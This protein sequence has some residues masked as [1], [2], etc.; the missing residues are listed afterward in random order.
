MSNLA[1]RLAILEDSIGGV[2]ENRLGIPQRQ[3]P[4]LFRKE[5]VTKSG[6]TFTTTNSDFLVDYPNIQNVPNKFVN[7]TFSQQS[8]GLLVTKNDL[9]V[10]FGRT[11]G[12]STFLEGIYSRESNTSKAIKAYIN[13]IY[14]AET[15]VLSSFD[16]QANIL[17]IL[18][19]SDKDVTLWRLILRRE[20]D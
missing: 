16:F 12:I 8:A 17:V 1:Q 20:Y 15:Q 6:S 4:I 9:L 10:E 3:K 7:L 18:D 5:T 14:N 11:T 19:D 2:I 13:P